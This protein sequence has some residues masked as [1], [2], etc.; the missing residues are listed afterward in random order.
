LLIL[1]D[2]CHKLRMVL[3]LLVQRRMG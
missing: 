1:F 3:Q 2:G